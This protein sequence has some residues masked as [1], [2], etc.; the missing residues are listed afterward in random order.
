MDRSCTLEKLTIAT[1]SQLQ[2]AYAVLSK[3][4]QFEW[5]YN[6]L[7]MCSIVMPSYLCTILSMKLSS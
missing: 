7:A 2:A 3:S 1:Q 6:I 4:V 5:D